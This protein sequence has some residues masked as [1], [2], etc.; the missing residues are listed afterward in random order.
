MAR[1]K[2]TTR[3]HCTHKPQPLTAVDYVTGQLRAERNAHQQTKKELQASRTELAL[4][5]AEIRRLQAR[6]PSADRP[7]AS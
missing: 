4:A 2:Q 7:K 1:V 6:T 5:M 3:K